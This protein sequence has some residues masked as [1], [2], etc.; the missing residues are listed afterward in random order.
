MW[1]GG[2][3]LASRRVSHGCQK[4]TMTT[5]TKKTI[6]WIAGIGAILVAAIGSLSAIPSSGGGSTAQPIPYSATTSLG[7]WQRLDPGGVIPGNIERTILI[8]ASAAV[9]GEHNANPFGSEYDAWLSLRTSLRPNQAEAFFRAAL[10]DEGWHVSSVSAI[11]GGFEIIASK[12]GSDGSF[13]EVG[14]K[15]PTP[16]PAGA[17]LQV[18]LL[19]VSFS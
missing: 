4:E 1:S 8:P 19:Q 3:E 11:P 13:W 17:T 16:G 15:D 12:A 10:P 9:V 7:A 5:R 18:R 6:G 2:A 14:I